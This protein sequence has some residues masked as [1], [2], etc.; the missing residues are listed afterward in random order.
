MDAKTRIRAEALK[1]F[2]RNGYEAVSV[3]GICKQS[4]VS[5]GSF[6]HAYATKEALGA[7]LWITALE[8]YHLEVTRPLGARPAARAGITGMLEAHLGWVVTSQPMARLLFEQ[9]R[10]EWLGYVQERQ[11][12][13][14]EKFAATISEWRE[15]LVKAGKL[16]DMPRG[17]FTAQ[18]IGPAQIFCRAWL[19]GRSDNDPRLQA[20][21][22]IA[23]AH[24]ALLA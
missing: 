15:P 1:L 4:R 20:K 17:M 18:L 7:D 23:C 12:A 6:F 2:S 24:R 10:P 21:H 22:L 3:A 19:S 9:V 8:N 16:L 13:E 11:A 14:N 5:N